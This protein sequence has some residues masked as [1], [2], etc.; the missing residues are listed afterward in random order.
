MKFCPTDEQLKAIT[1]K[2][3]VLVS[4]AA[5]SG[6]TAVL[7]ERVISMLCS[8]QT[9][10]SADRL[11]IVT[12]TNAAAAEMRTR[13]EKRLDEECRNN[14]GDVALLK[15]KH[16]LSSAKICTIDS[17]CIDLVREN[18]ERVDIS[19]DFKILDGTSLDAINRK[20]LNRIIGEYLK[21]KD[22]DFL[23][24]LDIIGTE[25]DEQSFID[26]VLGI[27]EY[28]RQLPFPKMWFSSFRDFY[29]SFSPENIWWKYCFE[30]AGEIVSGLREML[31]RGL[32]LLSDYEKANETYFP[33]FCELSE[34][35]AD[36]D[37]AL[38][39]NEWDNFY[40]LLSEFSLTSLPTLR[41]FSDVLEVNT[42]KEIYKNY[43]LKEI[44][45]L[46]KLFF[47]DKKTICEQ[48][49]KLLAPTRLLAEILCRFDDELF[50]EYKTENCFTFHNTEHMALKL[51]CECNSNGEIRLKADAEELLSRFDE[52]LVDEYQDT[53][54]LQ[55]ILFTVLSDNSQKLFAVGDIK[56]S[57]YAFRGANPKNF[58]KKKNNAILSDEALEDD[59]K[60]IILSSNFRCKSDVC[61]FINFFFT[62]FMTQNTGDILYNEEEKLLPAAVFPKVDT[63]ATELHIINCKGSEESKIIY[64]ARHIAEIIK[65]TV[66]NKKIIKLDNE[67][68]REAKYSDFAIL[69]RSA[70]LKAPII[71][72]ELKKQGIPVSYTADSFA[73]SIEVAVITSLLAVI[74]N[75]TLD[76]ELLSVAMSPIFKFSA[77][78]LAEI[79][80]EKRDGNLYSAFLKASENGNKKAES[81]IKEIKK[82][83]LAS[84]VNPLP[85]FVFNT[86]IET[87]YFD[88]VSSMEDGTRRKNNLLLFCDLAEQY[89]AANFPTLSGFLKYVKNQNVANN[90]SANSSDNAVKIMSIHASKGLQFPIC[91][92]ANLSGEF[93]SSESKESTLYTTDFGIG[94]KYFDEDIKQKV[95]TV[96]YQAILEKIRI[97]RLSEEL[98]LLY[99]AMTRTQDKLILTSSISN[100]DKK[101][102][103]LKMLLLASGNEINGSLFSKTKSYLDW[104]LISLLLHPNG[105]KLRGTASSIIAVA[106]NSKIDIEITDWADTASTEALVE[107][108]YELDADLVQKI[109]E[110]LSFEYPF[111]EL[112][113]VESKASVSKL[114]NSAESA[115]FAFATKPGFMSNKGIT[116]TEIGTAMHKVMQ[117]YDFEKFHDIGGELD[118]LLEWQFISEREYNAI[119]TEKIAKF[120]DSDIFKRILKSQNIKRE[121]R[122]LTEVPATQVAPH[123]DKRF[124]SES[125]IVQGAVDICFEEQDGIVILDFKTDRVDDINYLAESY[126]EQLNFYAKACEK[127]FGKPVKE[128]IIYSFNLSDYIL[129]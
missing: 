123:L 107:N 79:R 70:K 16:L 57:I 23:T 4:A 39:T 77:D 46:N 87:G 12:F 6:K 91:I 125:I 94:Y 119:S 74:D 8:K 13:I 38:K 89:S 121:M 26:F 72:E 99:V 45:K 93:N 108:N 32:D 76:I 95:T 114:A 14:P 1:T 15:Q 9:P 104:L 2:G 122:F 100:F 118:R 60:K 102:E 128:K 41:G 3:N 24:L 127:I 112:I 126:A 31:G 113:S 67:N 49:S 86:L 116:A 25:Y 63:S 21:K 75:P 80:A 40:N 124:E 69:L 27:F 52:I 42:A 22:E 5:G 58:L 109:N 129:I 106:S 88:L 20:V 110:N 11:L 85:T 28:S 66:D 10:I 120:F 48:F 115:K 105:D 101:I 36:F 44:E 97:E 64:E 7:V 34:R 98:R 84:V 96:G 35:L 59:T 68:L 30:R 50:A 56:Q 90:K 111:E 73:D 37:E 53:N 81:L 61:E 62:L 55:D 71:A 54:D 19:P 43:T 117:F 33:Y 103:D 78:E 18:F 92:V 83:R 51:L 65:E 47:A 29:S 17:F 82:F